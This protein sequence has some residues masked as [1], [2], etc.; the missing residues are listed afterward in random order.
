MKYG[1]NIRQ[2]EILLV[3]FP[4]TDLQR[5]K[6]RPV[7]VL[8][9]DDFNKK[10]EDIVVCAITSNLRQREY[11]VIITNNDLEE[12]KLRRD[13]LIKVTHIATISKDIVIKSVGRLNDNA[14]SNVK[15]DLREFF[16]FESK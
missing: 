6:Q 8:S 14:F 13:S 4:F 1:M 3:R 5:F 9:N 12:G 16:G 11:S 7:L 15:G 2:K 10:T